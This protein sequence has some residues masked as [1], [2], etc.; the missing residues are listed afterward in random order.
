MQS[1]QREETIVLWIIIGMFLVLTISFSFILLLKSNYSKH[2]DSKNK[3][4]ELNK[5]HLKKLELSSIKI[6]EQE[7][8]RIGNDLHDSIVNS[9]NILYLKSQAGLNEEVLVKDIQE[10]IN[11]TRRISHDLN[12]PLLEFQ[13]I[14]DAIRVILT[15]WEKYYIIQINIDCRAQ[16]FLK[17]EE[18]T[19]L[20]R[21][22]QEL[23]T[24]I[25]KHACCS[26]I[27]F[28]L[29]MSK[30]YLVIALEDDG[31]GFCIESAKKGI[32]LKSIK[33]RSKILNS[34]FKYKSQLTRGTKF[35]MLKKI[36]Q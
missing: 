25:H 4:D 3:I 14:Q 31:K 6:Q 5:S 28:Y 2:I 32:G 19:H 15:Q 10:T 12:P 36:T 11:L 17:V 30:K 26:S 20:I 24:N 16:L 22:I 18:K 9:L 13:S 27:K 1:W 29:R 35:L 8:Q 23:M 34:N 7:R 21:I 33:V